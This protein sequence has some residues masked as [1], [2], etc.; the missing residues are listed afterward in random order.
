MPDDIVNI[1]QPK[2]SSKMLK[3]IKLQSTTTEIVNVTAEERHIFN[4]HIFPR[5]RI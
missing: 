3:L 2:N 4:C 5:C 1:K